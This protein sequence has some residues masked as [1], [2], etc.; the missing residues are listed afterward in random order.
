MQQHKQYDLINLEQAL[1]RLEEALSADVDSDR[2]IIDATIQRF[3]FCIELF[4]KNFKNIATNEGTEV[5][6]PKQ[7]MIFA[8]KMK[9]IENENVWLQM[10][11]D[12]NTTSH[13]YKKYLADKIY[14]NI[15]TYA[16]EMRRVFN[17]L[18][19]HYQTN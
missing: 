19:A 12:R 6:S 2:F 3:E 5:L 16:P 9:W 1:T 10:L 8:Y 15:K 18:H 11:N 14:A 13:T 17:K 4:W 7:A